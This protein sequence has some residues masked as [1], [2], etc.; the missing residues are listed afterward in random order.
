MNMLNAVQENFINLNQ[1][2]VIYDICFIDIF[3]VCNVFFIDVSGSQYT[4]YQT[5]H[6]HTFGTIWFRLRYYCTWRL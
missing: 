4:I 2:K 1:L 5:Q 3:I 6:E